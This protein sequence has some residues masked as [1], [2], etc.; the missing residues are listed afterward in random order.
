[1]LAGAVAIIAAALAVNLFTSFPG[2]DAD[3]RAATDGGRAAHRSGSARAATSVVVA[4][5]P[6]SRPTP[7]P[8]SFLGLST[9][10]WS[11]PGF[12]GHMATFA[13][14]LSLLH[15]PGDGPLILRVGG[16]SAD[17]YLLA[18]A[19]SAALN[20][21]NKSAGKALLVKLASAQTDDTDAA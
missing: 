10:Y 7:V 6:G 9:E 13:R 19:A 8:P 16:K 4:L 1:M 2:R 5:A 17:P 11:L 14:V 15:V 12:A 3:T 21:G 18:L 20:T